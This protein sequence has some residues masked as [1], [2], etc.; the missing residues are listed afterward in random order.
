MHKLLLDLMKLNIERGYNILII[1]F[2]G[3][4]VACGGLDN[5]CSIYRYVKH[6][7]FGV[8]TILFLV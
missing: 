6:T 5:I 3:S 8:V 1:H 4:F 2:I 7:F